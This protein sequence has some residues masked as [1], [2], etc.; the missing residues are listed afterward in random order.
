[1]E[2]N[3]TR[4]GQ[5]PQ[6]KNLKSPKIQKIVTLEEKLFK[7]TQG[8]FTETDKQEKHFVV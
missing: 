4:R 2:N 3:S 7:K 6:K 1:M 8:N 5:V